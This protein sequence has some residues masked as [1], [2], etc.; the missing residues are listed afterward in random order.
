[1]LKAS[2]GLQNYDMGKDQEFAY[3]LEQPLPQTT[4][5]MP[6]IQHALH[7]YP[8]I[9]STTLSSFDPAATGT[10]SLR[11]L[12]QPQTTFNHMNQLIFA[13]QQFPSLQHSQ[14]INS[15]WP[16]GIPEGTFWNP[17]A[18]PNTNYASQRIEAESAYPP[19]IDGLPPMPSSSNSDTFMFGLSNL[20]TPMGQQTQDR[21]GQVP[22]PSQLHD[23]MQLQPDYRFDVVSSTLANSLPNAANQHNNLPPT[24]LNSRFPCSVHIMIPPSCISL[25]SNFPPLTYFPNNLAGSNSLHPTQ[26]LIPPNVPSQLLGNW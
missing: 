17:I 24:H 2:S 12:I 19:R 22:L 8:H 10:D 18:V 16:Q 5:S 25:A 1:M 20:V 15:I 23:V 26:Q 6:P 9:P 3:L 13:P 11:S 7:A 4:F 21:A 14:G